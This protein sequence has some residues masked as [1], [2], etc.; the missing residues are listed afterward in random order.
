[1]LVS[2]QVCNMTMD[3]IRRDVTDKPLSNEVGDAEDSQGAT[4][5]AVRV[6]WDC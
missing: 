3:Q 2:V 1:M 6:R 5:E 4:E